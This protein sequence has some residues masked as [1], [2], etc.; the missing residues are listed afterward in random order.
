MIAFLSQENVVSKNPNVVAVLNGHYHG[1]SYETV[2]FDDDG[3][4]VKERT[5]YQICTDWQE[6]LEGGAGYIKFLYFDLDGNRIYTTSYSPYLE[7]YN[8]YDEPAVVLN[9]DGKKATGYDA[10][11]LDVNFGS[12]NQ[13][14]AASGFTAAIKTDKKI[15]SVKADENGNATAAWTGLEKRH[16]VCLVL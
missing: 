2:K 14:L 13:T 16:A 3:D 10:M 7:D 5:V 12:S 1:S 9:E 8:Y 6:G 4:G 15:A 11:I